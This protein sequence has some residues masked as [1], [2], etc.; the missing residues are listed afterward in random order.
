M[1]VYSAGKSCRNRFEPNGQGAQLIG[2]SWSSKY[3]PSKHGESL[4][5]TLLVRLVHAKQL[6][7]PVTEVYVETLQ[8]AQAVW[9]TL[10]LE[11]PAAHGVQ[12]APTPPSLLT[13]HNA[14]KH[15]RAGPHAALCTTLTTQGA[16][17]T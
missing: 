9:P 14:Q 10:A 4:H 7:E 3:S 1:R 17:A 11:K 8:A 15:E 6:V 2:V 12:V 13:K 5:S 16:R